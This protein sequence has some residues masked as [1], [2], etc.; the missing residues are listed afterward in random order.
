MRWVVVPSLPDPEPIYTE[1]YN[2]FQAEY[3]SVLAE[4]HDACSRGKALRVSFPVQEST[5]KHDVYMKCNLRV[6]FSVFV[7]SAAKLVGGILDCIL[8]T[9]FAECP[10]CKKRETT[11]LTW[12]SPVKPDNGSLPQLG[13]RFPCSLRG[14]A[15]SKAE[16]NCDNSTHQVF[17]CRIHGVCTES[18]RIAGKN[19][20]YGEYMICSACPDRRV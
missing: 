10:P 16:C 18:K 14:L 20:K 3:L 4:C 17:S 11:L 9:N 12:A 13:A 5:D 1:C 8:N 7:A 2:A 15:I 6:K 19:P